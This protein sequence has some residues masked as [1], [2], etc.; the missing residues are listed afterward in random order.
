M[1]NVCC[2]LGQIFRKNERSRF[3][4]LTFPVLII[5]MSLIFLKEKRAELV[6]QNKAKVQTQDGMDEL[7]AGKET[8]SSG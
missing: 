2:I 1:L 6:R 7:P 4:I 3:C 8:A 5:K